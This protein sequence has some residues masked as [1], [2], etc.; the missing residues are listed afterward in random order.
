MNNFNATGPFEMDRKLDL[1]SINI[2]WKNP[3]D[4][5]KSG[6]WGKLT[7]DKFSVLAFNCVLLILAMA[8]CLEQNKIFGLEFIHKT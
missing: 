4:A 5:S 3:K 2:K 6:F 1:I 7:I 8:H